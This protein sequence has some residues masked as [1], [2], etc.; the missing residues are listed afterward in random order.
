[1]VVL[2]HMQQMRTIR[3]KQKHVSDYAR[4]IA[5]RMDRTFDDAKQALVR[6]E[7][8]GKADCSPEHLTQMG[9]IVLDADSIQDI[10][11]FRDGELVCTN[12]GVFPTPIPPKEADMDVGEGYS[13]TFAVEPKLFRAKPLIE[14]RRGNYGVLIRPGRLIDLVADTSMTLGVATNQGQVLELSGTVTPELIRRLLSDQSAGIDDQYIF[15]S[16]RAAGLVT[17]AIVDRDQERNAATSD[18]RDILPLS[19]AISLAL[20]G[21]VIWVSRQQ[22]SPEKTLELAIRKREFVVHYQPIVELG[23]RRCVA[24]EA[25]VRWRQRDGGIVN[26]ELFIPLAEATGL[27]SQL[28][29]LVM[30]MVMEDMG[31]LLR[32]DGQFHISVNIPAAD[33]ESGRFLS[34]LAAAV[35]KAGIS[36]S[37]VWLEVTERGFINAAAATSAIETARTAGY[38]ITIDDF[39]TGYSSLSLLEGLAL[40]A[41]KIDKSFVDAIGREAVKSVVTPHIIAMAH[42][43]KL[44][45]IAEGIETLEQEAF[46]KD[47]NVQFGQGWLYAKALPFEQFQ[48]FY[49]RKR[50]Y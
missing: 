7:A 40:D 47:A 28:T 10:G 9:Q 32:N 15:A 3:V 13:L 30:E 46:L 1:M 45:M 48:A 26:P 17:F 23:T 38:Q 24:A 18:W 14:L 43:L 42:E 39:G 19:L 11:F 31:P 6:V 44:C 35:K 49:R 33:M 4:W 25:L 20:I 27:I 12:L 36:P 21:I 5:V 16:R 41:L 22:L 29:D 37:Q 2:S 50:T 34:G 8:E